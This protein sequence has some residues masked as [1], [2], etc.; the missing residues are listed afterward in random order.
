[1]AQTSPP[2]VPVLRRTVKDLPEEEK[3]A[4]GQLGPSRLETIPE[5][6]QPRE[7]QKQEEEEEMPLFGLKAPVWPEGYHPPTKKIPSGTVTCLYTWPRMKLGKAVAQFVGFTRQLLPCDGD[8]SRL[9]SSGM[10]WKTRP[11]E[12]VGIALISLQASA[13]DKE[14]DTYVN[15][16]GQKMV[17]K[18]AVLKAEKVDKAWVAALEKSR[19]CHTIADEKVQEMELAIPAHIELVQKGL[20][21]GLDGSQVRGDRT[22]FPLFNDYLSHLERYGRGGRIKDPFRDSRPTDDRHERYNNS[23]PSVL[24]RSDNAAETALFEERARLWDALSK[25]D[26]DETITERFSCVLCKNGCQGLGQL[27]EHVTSKA[28]TSTAVLFHSR[29]AVMTLPI[30]GTKDKVVKFDVKDLRHWIES[31]PGSGEATVAAGG[32][33]VVDATTMG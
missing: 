6:P 24:V 31:A 22:N 4:R 3:P 15:Y 25:C 33:E 17:V 10:L 8:Y 16:W 12:P 11:L 32:R 18:V 13:N 26:I 14:E 21:K 20:F 30:N 1:M 7:M 19:S 29:D 28:H 23:M 5:R 9:P 2:A 27:V